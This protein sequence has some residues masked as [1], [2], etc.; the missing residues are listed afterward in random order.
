MIR[1]K[2]HER[3]L[4]A[5]LNAHVNAMGNALSHIIARSRANAGEWSGAE[6]A[7]ERI[8]LAIAMYFTY[9]YRHFD[10]ARFFDNYKPWCP[11]Q[12]RTGEPETRR[13]SQ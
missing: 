7:I 1:M 2:T 13:E 9:K 10:A 8:E 5:H 12:K 3:A 11:P 4:D 6:E